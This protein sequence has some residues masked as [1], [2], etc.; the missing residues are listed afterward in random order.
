V[1]AVDINRRHMIEAVTKMICNTVGG[2]VF[3][4][5]ITWVVVTIVTR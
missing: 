2:V 5:C 1:V 4:L 3:I